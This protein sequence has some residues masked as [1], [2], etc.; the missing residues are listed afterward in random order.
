MEDLRNQKNLE[1]S[2]FTINNIEG[3]LKSSNKA[4]KQKI[5][6]NLESKLKPI[7]QEKNTNL[8][9]KLLTR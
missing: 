7:K 5:T 3:T 9:K 2:I 6:L 8:D 4:K 1:E